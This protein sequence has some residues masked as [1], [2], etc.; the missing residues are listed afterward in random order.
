MAFYFDLTGVVALDGTDQTVGGR[1][2]GTCGGVFQERI[3]ADGWSCFVVVV[4]RRWIIRWTWI[5]ELFCRGGLF[6]DGSSDGH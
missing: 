5:I 2:G 4:V 6:E 1:A 3:A